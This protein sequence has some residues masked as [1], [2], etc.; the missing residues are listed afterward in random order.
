MSASAEQPDCFG[1][2]TE[3]AAPVRNSWPRATVGTDMS[4]AIKVDIWSDIA[5]PWCFIGKRRFESAAAAFVDDE[6]AVEIE[7]HSFELAPDTPVDF[8]G[9]GVD[10]LV[11][12]KH[13][14]AEQ[15]ARMLE[16]VGDVATQVGL[17][18][19]FDAIKH[20]NTLKAHQLLHFAKAHGKQVEMKERLLS[21]FFEEGRH[22]GHVADLADLAVDIGLDRDAVIASLETDEFLSAVAADKEQAQAYGI[23]GVP[24][25]VIDGKY[26]ISGAQAPATFEQALA[27]AWEARS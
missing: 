23:N 19:D 27:E 1:A 3:V 20:T 10:F 14:P 12:H 11:E 24:F 25:F 17:T 18:Y 6:H 4:N 5:C 16:H 26:G 7:F 13:M 9:S 21:A 22:V 8:D 15:V 2:M